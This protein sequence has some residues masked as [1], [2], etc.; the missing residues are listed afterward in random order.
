MLA[1]TTVMAGACGGNDEADPPVVGIAEAGFDS[2]AG[3]LR[4]LA[5][6]VVPPV[7]DEYRSG[8]DLRVVLT[9]VNVGAAPDA[10]IGASSPDAARVEIRWDRDCD[11]RPD[12]VSRLPIASAEAAAPE[13]PAGVGPFDRYDL[14]VVA[15]RRDLPAGTTIPLTLTF[16]RAGKLNTS[17]YVQPRSANITEPVRRC[18]LPASPPAR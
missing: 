15:V 13:K 17:A 18:V 14:L 8:S 9:I 3:T 4:I 1:V 16:E 2:V 6:H 11:G 5:V 7:G 12:V 10:L